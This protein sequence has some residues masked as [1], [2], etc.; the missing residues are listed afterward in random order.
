MQPHMGYT[1]R[2]EV[3][4]FNSASTNEHVYTIKF[5]GDGSHA[6]TLDTTPTFG[7]LN[8]ASLLM[9]EIAQ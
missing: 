4:Y 9:E 2:T 7:G 8:R 6:T 5:G 1:G 3:W